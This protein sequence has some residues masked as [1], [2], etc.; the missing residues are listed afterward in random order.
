VEKKKLL[1]VCTLAIGLTAGLTNADIDTGLVGHWKLDETSGT[2]AYDSVG[3]NN[4]TLIGSPTWTAGAPEGFNPTGG[5]DFDSTSASDARYVNCGNDA[6]LEITGDRSV[7]AWF[8][9]DDWHTLWA[10]LV[11]KGGDGSYNLIRSRRSSRYGGSDNGIAF[12]VCGQTGTD[13]E[14]RQVPPNNENVQINGKGGT[15]FTNSAIDDVRIYNRALSP[16]EV[17]A[18]MGAI[19]ATDGNSGPDT[20]R[21]GDVW[22]LK[23]DTSSVMWE[24]KEWT[25]DNPSWS[26]NEYDVT[27]TVTFTH[28]SSGSTHI[29]EMFYDGPNTWKFRFTGTKTGKWTFAT[30]SSDPELNGLT[31]NVTVSPNP[32][33]NARG[34]LTNRGNKYAIQVGNNGELKAYRLNVYMNG[35]GFPEFIH[36]LTETTTIN[37]YIADA[38][39]YGFDTIFVHVCNSWFDFGSLGRDDH[40]SKNPDPHTFAALEDVIATARSQGMRVMIWAWGDHDH[41]KSPRGGVNRIPDRRIQRYIAARLGPLPGWTMGYGFDLHEWVT[42]AEL[43]EWAEYLHNHFGW[44]HMVWARDRFHPEL[45]VKSYPHIGN[46]GEPFSYGDA[47]DNLNSDPSRPHFYGE[48]FWL[49]RPPLKYGPYRHFKDPVWTMENTRRAL[50]HYTMAGGVGS[51]WGFYKRGKHGSPTPPPYPNLEQLVTANRFWVGRFLLNMERANSL[52]DGYCLKTTTNDNYVFYKEDTNSVQMNLS[53]MGTA[54]PAIAVDT[55]LD[56]AEINL[57]TL[58]PTSQTWTAP[59]VSDWAVA[60]GD[61]D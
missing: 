49:D 21:K 59:Y 35:T 1:W 37:A 45:D 53:G 10:G 56:Y 4:G 58:N 57:G 32:D 3:S 28:T 42:E 7:A 31:G 16:G 15:H 12:Q 19:V 39:Q 51:W 18:V 55:K 5:I 17:K 24:Y 13:I 9:I 8:R 11:T 6:S 22:S 43:G 61:F 40:S 2:A 29:T 25:V 30:A 50:W 48:R 38:R 14:S 54:L 33:P 36:N 26:G 27:A 52:T 47:V 41:G 23:T 34:F 46:E 20:P 44:R 60:V